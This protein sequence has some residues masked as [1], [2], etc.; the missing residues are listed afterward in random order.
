MA[1]SILS[2]IN[3][4]GGSI[5]IYCDSILNVITANDRHSK[6]CPS[7]WKAAVLISHY[8][9][10]GSSTSYQNTLMQPIPI[11]NIG[12]SSVTYNAIYVG[13]NGDYSVHSTITIN[14]SSFSLSAGSS[15]VDTSGTIIF[16]A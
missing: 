4:A 12:S 9:Y 1:E 2:S 3:L 10:S 5:N 6:S 11:F 7:G 14:N 13:Q 16:A 8:Y 15:F